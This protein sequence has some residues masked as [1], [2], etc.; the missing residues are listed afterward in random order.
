MNVRQTI[1]NRIRNKISDL[2]KLAFF[3]STHDLW[4]VVMDKLFVRCHTR[5]SIF[6]GKLSKLLP[7][8]YYIVWSQRNA[9][10]NSNRILISITH[11]D[12]RTV[13]ARF[14]MMC[15][16]TVCTL[17]GAADLLE[18]FCLTLF[19]WRVPGSSPG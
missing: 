4:Q 15:I 1:S 3:F 14:L 9:C 13:P 19:R 12:L 2:Q 18:A 17:L 5:S 16:P 8:L 6:V 10:R 11:S 7:S